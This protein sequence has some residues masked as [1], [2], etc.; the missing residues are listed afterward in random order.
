M[1]HPREAVLFCFFLPVLSVAGPP[2]GFLLPFSEVGTATFKVGS[3]G[4]L[5]LFS[6][7][8]TPSGPKRLHTL[9]THSADAPLL[10]HVHLDPSRAH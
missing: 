3:E 1:I 8:V 10:L 4:P 6:M 7:S 5:P 9:F 2:F